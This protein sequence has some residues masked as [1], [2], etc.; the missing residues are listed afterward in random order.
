MSV[1]GARSNFCFLIKKTALKK[2]LNRA[3]CL[4]T[5]PL[6]YDRLPGDFI[7]IGDAAGMVDPFCGEGMRHAIDT[8]ILAARIVAAGIR[9][10]A[11]Y[12]DMKWQYESEWERH[13]F[14]RRAAGAGMRRISR[15]FGKVLPV[16]PAW[17][18]NR[19]WS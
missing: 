14:L 8:G 17:L 2:Y 3:D 11:S 1:E 12:E 6:A 19:L 5:G 9:R 13:W 10:C 18:V 15:H 4:I 16:V 7:A